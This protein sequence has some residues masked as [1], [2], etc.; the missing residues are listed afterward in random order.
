[1]TAISNRKLSSILNRALPGWRDSGGWTYNVFPNEPHAYL[2]SR[3]G[4]K[5]LFRATTISIQYLQESGS[6]LITFHDC[7]AGWKRTRNNSRDRAHQFAEINE[8]TRFLSKKMYFRH[9]NAYSDNYNIIDFTGKWMITFCHE[10]DWFL[11]AKKNQI[12]A[13]KGKL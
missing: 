8:L 13:L 9:S 12:E 4:I 3:V 5:R 6:P 2:S 1:M 7:A 11:F 10:D